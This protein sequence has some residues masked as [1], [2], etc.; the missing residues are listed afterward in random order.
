VE[1]NSINFIVQELKTSRP[2]SRSVSVR[3]APKRE[4]AM[5]CGSSLE[6][7]FFRAAKR[8]LD[9]AAHRDRDRE[10]PIRL[11]NAIVAKCF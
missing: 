5:R 11:A 8:I 1:T 10:Y 7:F 9:D 4:Q 3:L 6:I 2:T